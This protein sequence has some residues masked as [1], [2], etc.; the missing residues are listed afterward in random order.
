MTGTGTKTASKPSSS[1]VLEKKLLQ[2]LELS[3][4]VNAKAYELRER[5]VGPP[6]DAEGTVECPPVQGFWGMVNG[7]V[8]D[9]T[10]NLNLIHASLEAMD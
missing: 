7:K 8:E 9:L 6:G 2:A 5:F 10:R 3:I 4:T 1:A